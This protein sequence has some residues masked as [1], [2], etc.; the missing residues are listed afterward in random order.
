[1]KLNGILF[2]AC[3]A[4]MMLIGILFGAPYLSLLGSAMLFVFIA[5]Y[6]Y[7]RKAAQELEI[8]CERKIDRS[9]IAAGSSIPGATSL[10]F[11]PSFHINAKESFSPSLIPEGKTSGS[12]KGEIKFDYIIKAEDYGLSRIGPVSLVIDDPLG[13]FSFAR[14][15]ESHSELFVYPDLSEVKKFDLALKRRSTVQTHGMRKGHEKGTGTEFVNLRDYVPG[16]ELRFIDW[17]ATARTDKVMVR[18]FQSEKKQRVMLVV[19]LSQ[20]MDTGAGRT[21][22]DAAVNTSVLLSYIALKRGD[23]V[24]CST[25]SDN[26]K[27]YLK[28]S[29]SRVQFYRMLDLFSKSEIKGETDYISSFERLTDIHIKRSIIILFTD[30]TKNRNIVEAIRLVV[31]H[32]HAVMVISP[33]EPWFDPYAKQ[34]PVSK[35]IA[36]AVEEKMAMEIDD[37]KSELGKM[38]VSVVVV[39]PED[40]TQKS[41]GRY[42][43]AVNLG[44]A[45]V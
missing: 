4:S 15:L 42:I 30:I 2:L 28:P 44:L 41:I 5:S 43:H 22:A 45:T 16:D 39:S 27:D 25:F 1:M 34:D 37:I 33:F 31:A 38:G 29:D 17:K 10:S 6:F 7:G 12:G 24:G 20:G 18:T 14:E 3:I 23:L 19:D 32:G 40:I 26:V 11:D 9:K 13:L 8:K 36:R 35:N 21:M